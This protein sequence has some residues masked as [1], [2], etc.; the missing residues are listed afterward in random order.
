MNIPDLVNGCFELF[1]AYAAYGN[2]KQIRKDKVVKGFDP[3]STVFF[4]TWGI[5]NL[6]Y[7]YNLEQYLSWFGGMAIVAVNMLWL[8]HIV[9]YR[10]KHG[11]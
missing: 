3:K 11:K 4:T 10:R 6:Y 8:G 7:Y 1:G 2:V 9:Y 5:W